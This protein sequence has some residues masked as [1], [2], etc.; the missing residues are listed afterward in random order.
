VQS[1]TVYELTR[2][3]LKPID[4]TGLQIGQ[5]VLQ[6]HHHEVGVVC[7]AT[8]R[9]Y[10]VIFPDG[11]SSH[12]QTVGALS[13][14]TRIEA[15]AGFAS[16]EEVADLFRLRD[17]FQANAR[18]EWEEATQKKQRDEAAF[19]IQLRER[20]PWAVPVG[21]LS[22]AARDALLLAQMRE[23]PKLGEPMPATTATQSPEETGQYNCTCGNKTIFTGIDKRGYPGKNCEC[24][25]DPCTCEVELKQDFT[26]GQDFIDYD[27]FS[28]GGSGATID[29]YTSIVCRACGETVW[30]ASDG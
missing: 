12:G 10:F 7:E 28:G 30:E 1:G 3:G 18:L 8:S 4:T 2:G 29:R 20:Y 17:E 24:G 11:S 19:V 27:A 14:F 22:D 16:A 23:V 6:A 21:K 5:R 9:G 25:N 15:V 13:P 26:V